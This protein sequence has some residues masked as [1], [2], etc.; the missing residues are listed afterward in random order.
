MFSSD[1]QEVFLFDEELPG[2][3]PPSEDL[4]FI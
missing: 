1:H 3:K 2:Y 4:T